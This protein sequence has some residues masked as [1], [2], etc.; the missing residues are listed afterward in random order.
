MS[1]DDIGAIKRLRDAPAPEYPREPGSA[2][3]L[4][5]CSRKL[6]IQ[7]PL[8]AVSAKIREPAGGALG[9]RSREGGSA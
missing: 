4:H 6:V 9:G 1:D 5:H 3:K 2:P 7:A 8:I